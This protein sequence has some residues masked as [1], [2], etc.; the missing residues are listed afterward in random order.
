MASDNDPLTMPS[1]VSLQPLTAAPAAAQL[2]RR[3]FLAAALLTPAALQQAA[4]GSGARHVGAV[5]LAAPGAS[6]PPFGRLLGDGLDARLFTDLSQLVDPQ[7]TLAPSAINR[8][9]AIS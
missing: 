7:S 2:T 9:L 5:P 3:H 6:S 4:R 1:A 8:Q